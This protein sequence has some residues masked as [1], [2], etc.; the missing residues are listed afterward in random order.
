MK[1]TGEEDVPGRG[2]GEGI[3]TGQTQELQGEAGPG[4]LV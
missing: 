3:N 4:S 1:D 2:S